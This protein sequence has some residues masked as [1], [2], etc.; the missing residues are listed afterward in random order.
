MSK[1][2]QNHD[3]FEDITNIY[4]E[5]E[6]YRDLILK[7]LKNITSKDMTST[8]ITL[9]SGLNKIDPLK[10]KQLIDY[11]KLQGIFID[12]HQKVWD[13]LNGRKK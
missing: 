13:K 9:L 12:K 6:I 3:S 7:D 10:I 5:F 2:R 8:N 11:L 4:R 1:F